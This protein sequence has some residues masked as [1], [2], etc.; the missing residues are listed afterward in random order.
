MGGGLPAQIW[1]EVMLVAHQGLAPADLPGTFRPASK[2]EPAPP[3]EGAIATSTRGDGAGGGDRGGPVE[4][5]AGPAKASWVGW[6]GGMLGMGAPAT[7][8]R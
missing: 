8:S 7:A 3:R 1:R 2:P 6:L 4:A 5:G